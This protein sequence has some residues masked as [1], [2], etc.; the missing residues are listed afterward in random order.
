MFNWPL[1]R[2]HTAAQMGKG[3][4][5]TNPGYEA[6]NGTNGPPGKLIFFLDNR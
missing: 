3:R 6:K 5:G 2:K 1:M 4:I